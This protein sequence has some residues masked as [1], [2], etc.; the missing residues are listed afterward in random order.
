MLVL[1]R[2]AFSISRRL[3]VYYLCILAAGAL[4]TVALTVLVGQV[5]GAAD[6]VA[7]GGPIG[8]FAW[9]LAAMAVVFAIESV[10][11]VLR[12]AVSVMLEMTILR[13]AAGR[14]VDPMI[15]PRRIAHLDDPKVQDA[16]GRATTE[17]QMSIDQSVPMAGLLL[18]SRIGLIGSLVVLVV[19]FHWWVV[20]VLAASSLFVE[21][22]FVRIISTESE[23][24]RGRTEGQREGTYL[25]DLAMLHG[26]KEIRVFGLSRW[27]TRRHGDAMLEA[28]EPIWR[29][30]RWGAAR[31]LLTF[32]PHIAVYA[33]AM[34][35]AAKEAYDGDLSLSAA[36][37][38]LPAILAV[39]GGFSPWLVS[40]V[41]RALSTYRAM[42]EIP[43]LIAG[44][45]PQP[46]GHA[47][48]MSRAPR[49]EI[50]LDGVSFR[51]PDAER[52]VLTGLDLTI[53]ADEALAIVGVNGAGKSTLVKLL[54]GAYLPT[55]GQIT[56]DGVDLAALDADSLASWQRRIAT[57]VQDFLRF[58]LPARDNVS[59]GAGLIAP[60][61]APP[62]DA[63]D[64]ATVAAADRAGVLPV[65]ERLPAGWATT[66]DKSYDGGVDL[67]GGEWQRIALARALR[68][69]DAGAR[70]LVLDEP[71]A[72]LDARSEAQLV[73]RY[74]EL[75]S[76]IASLIISH[77]F[78]VVRDA[79]RICVLGDGH[80]LE[81]GTHDELIAA[82]GHYATMFRLQAQRYVTVPGAAA[83][84]PGDTDA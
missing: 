17:S 55:A 73:D 60:L 35:L 2:Y 29:R 54:T 53:H 67:S 19:F 37:T 84:G 33:G 46:V 81:S 25:F 26:T 78:S 71:A 64:R 4:A 32:T 43:E 72:A 16:Y 3:T 11:P 21:W 41:R 45:H 42:Q 31:N 52:D 51:Y 36:V 62:D 27:L 75:T 12:A 38:V 57:I 5:V 30:R 76:G 15:A 18:S 66:L 63:D 59:F 24:W 40:S 77:R 8:R 82:G 61:D 44:R 50:R 65:I 68:A 20:L 28:F 23:V 14:V 49:H 56:V 10:L 80:I 1:L 48:D 7:H 39:G 70:V 13:D 74:L 83:G 58:P 69:V 22:W 79:D 34:L 6:G 47:V 9:L